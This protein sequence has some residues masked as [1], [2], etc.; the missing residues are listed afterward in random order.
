MENA[1]ENKENPQSEEKLNQQFAKNLPYSSQIR[2]E[3]HENI[4][5]RD[6]KNSCCA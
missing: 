2:V 5:R 3:N 6:I 4:R 1:R